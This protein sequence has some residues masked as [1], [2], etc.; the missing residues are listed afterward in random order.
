MTLCK[1]PVEDAAALAASRPK[2]EQGK[3]QSHLQTCEGRRQWLRERPVELPRS[4]VVGNWVAVHCP[5]AT[6]AALWT[7]RGAL[8]VSRWNP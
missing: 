6:Q 4:A 1:Y 5:A 7:H 8:R 2:P 3:F